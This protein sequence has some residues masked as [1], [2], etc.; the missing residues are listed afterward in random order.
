VLK[1]NGTLHFRLALSVSLVHDHFI[2]LCKL[3]SS[4]IHLQ[5]L[6]ARLRTHE[7]DID[8]AKHIYDSQEVKEATQTNHQTDD[9][10]QK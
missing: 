2:E 8:E 4:E 6:A 7:V 1:H 3:F 5:S 10:A 9:W